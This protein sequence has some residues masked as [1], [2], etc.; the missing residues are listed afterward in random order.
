[1]MSVGWRLRRGGLAGGPVAFMRISVSDPDRLPELL[2]FLRER[3]DVVAEL[4]DGTQI[5]V[6]LLGSRDV[7]ANADE[8]ELRLEPWRAA[9]GGVHVELHDSP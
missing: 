2:S 3:P 4:A 6:S 8:L 7:S 1:M 9:N 5:A